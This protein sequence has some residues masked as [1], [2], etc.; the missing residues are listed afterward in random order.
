V[1]RAENLPPAFGD[2]FLFAPF[3]WAPAQQSID[4]DSAV[5]IDA[6]L[7]TLQAEPAL[8]HSR[9]FSIIPHNCNDF[10]LTLL[11]AASLK[12]FRLVLVRR[13]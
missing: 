2:A 12:R 10:S 3:A 7:T 9:V 11:S 5:F 13:G 1:R 8:F 4:R 6:S